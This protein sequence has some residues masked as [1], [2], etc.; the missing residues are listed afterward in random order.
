MANTYG[1][2]W[3]VS[4]LPAFPLDMQLTNALN[5]T[6]LARSAPTLGAAC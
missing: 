2:V 1:A 3:E 4:Q 6:V 5:Q